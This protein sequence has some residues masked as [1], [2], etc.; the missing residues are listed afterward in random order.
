[1]RTLIIVALLTTSL[2]S[3]GQLFVLDSLNDKGL[4]KFDIASSLKTNNP[5]F[6]LSFDSQVV[7][8][9]YD[10]VFNKSLL[11]IDPNWIESIH[12]YRG[13]D[14]LD[15]YGDGAKYGAVLIELKLE[16]SDKLPLELK[17]R[18][19]DSKN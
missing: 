2:S 14:A 6:I 9:K 18:F 8:V 19:T 1:M 15:K 16:S 11:G 12:I 10:E 13:Q 17:K 7:E 3:Y 5:L 4:E